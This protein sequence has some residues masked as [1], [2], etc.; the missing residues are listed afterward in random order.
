MHIFKAAALASIFGLVASS[1]QAADSLASYGA[2]ERPVMLSYS[3]PLQAPAKADAGD[4]FA[5]SIA[6]NMHTSI[7]SAFDLNSLTLN[8]LNVAQA[9][10]RLYADGE[11]DNYMPL[12]AIG[13]VVG[14]AFLVANQDNDHGNDSPKNGGCPEGT[15]YSPSSGG[16]F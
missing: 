4:H 10:D 15:I 2:D 12:I 14:A 16:C 9:T 1:A 5:L 3:L 13:V 11:D 6:G 8:G 7:N